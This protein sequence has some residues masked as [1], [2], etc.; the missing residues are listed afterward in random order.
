MENEKKKEY[1]CI[2]LK[3]KSAYF[4]IENILTCI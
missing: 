3:K 2:K 1:S 4:A